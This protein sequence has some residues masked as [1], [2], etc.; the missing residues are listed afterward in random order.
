MKISNIFR[1]TKMWHRD[2]KGA[3]AVEEIML[4]DLR[5]AGLPQTFDFSKQNAVS[6]KH[7]RGNNKT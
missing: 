7:D 6:A 3:T 2:I 4:T 1:I 5:D